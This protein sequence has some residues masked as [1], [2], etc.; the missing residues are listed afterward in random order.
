LSRR[1]EI[2]WLRQAAQ[3]GDVD[4]QFDLACA[5]ADGDGV[6]QNTR[7]A[8][9][10]FLKAALKKDREAMTAVGYCLLNGDGVDPDHEA[11]VRWFRE[12]S[13]LGDDDAPLYLSSCLLYGEGVE[14][15]ITAGLAMARAAWEVDEDPQF[16]Y[17]LATAYEDLLG[18]DEGARAWHRRA[19]DKGDEE[20]MMSL[21]DLYRFGRGVK[22]NLKAAFRWYEAAAEAGNLEGLATMAYCYAAGEGVRRNEAKAV[23]IYERAAKLGH[24]DSRLSL[25]ACYLHGTGVDKNVEKGMA[26]LRELAEEGPA[27]AMMLAETLYEGEL[28]PQDLDAVV[29][30]LNKAAE[31]D[32]PE[33]VTFLGVLHWNGEGVPQNRALARKLYRRAAGLG[34]AHS[35]YNLGLAG[36]DDGPNELAE[37]E[38]PPVDW[39][40]IEESSN[41]GHGPSAV[42][43]AEHYIEGNGVEVDAERGF[44]CLQAAV[45][46]E[47][48][49]ALFFAAECLRDGVGVEVDPGQAMEFFELAQLLGVDTR[50]ERGILRRKLRGLDDP[51]SQ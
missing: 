46:V 19:A 17:L 51:G 28:A 34:E 40:L 20:A 10:W 4:A 31:A 37:G 9:R 21:G 18:D 38:D 12:A 8:Y 13:D 41:L 6:P 36:G 43:L 45:S 29:L 7:T 25:V 48:P 22:R 26:L 50:V 39:A 24:D 35:L 42:L 11:A 1:E 14:Q 16:A 30:W 23:E 49:D 27:G 44:A 32:V 15:D 47:D 33:A 2:T 5:Y 3:G